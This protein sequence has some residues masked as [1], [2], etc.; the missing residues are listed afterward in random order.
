[1]IRL[2]PTR[3]VLAAAG[4]VAIA[5][6]GAELLAPAAFRE[7]YGI[8]LAGNLSLASETRAAGGGLLAVGALVLAGAFVARLRFAA[9]L[10]G[11]S[12][13]AGYGLARGL[14]LVADGR[15]ADGLLVAAAV[16]LAVGAACAAILPFA[17]RSTARVPARGAGPAVR[18]GPG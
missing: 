12:T 1:M 14:S 9:A 17:G 15:P 6:G 3:L 11:A 18:P 8:D 4:L 13:Y 16:E 2:V 7:T 10:L 5:V